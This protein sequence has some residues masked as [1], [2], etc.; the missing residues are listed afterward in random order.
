MSKKG[1]T[2]RT[3]RFLKLAKMTASVAGRYAGQKVQNVFASEAQADERRS[4]VYTRMADEVVDTLGELKGAVMKLGQIASQTQDFLPREFSAALQKLQKEA[5]PVEF[6]VIEGQIVR[7]LGATPDQLFKTFDRAPFAAASIGQVHRAVTKSGIEVVV[8]V[9]YP[10]VD[11]SCDSDLKQLKLTL[12]LGGLLKVP[13]ESVDE[14]FEEVKA[15]LHEELDYENEAR[16]I[17]RFRDFHASHDGILVPRVIDR[18]STRR[19]LTLEYLEG[20]HVN[21]LDRKGYD[22]PT[23]NLIGERLFRVLVEQ[24]FMF[25]WIHGDPHPGNFAFRKDGSVVI[26]DF[27]CVKQL[28]PDIV[29]AYA[30]AIEASLAEDY[31]AL[32]DAM[33]RL[34]ARVRG[35]PSPG[36][37]YY[38]VWRDIFLQPFLAGEPYDFRSSEMHL[39][40]AK[41][42]ALFFRY[43]DHFR[44]PVESMFIDRM[45]GG[46]YWLA[47]NLG[48]QG[49]FGPILADYVKRYRAGPGQQH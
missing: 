11:E 25:Q 9:Q 3:G 44:P 21:D 19:V 31:D 14:L 18:F 15:R 42:T 40:V 45:M 47:R 23:I 43:F 34:G 26:Y 27:G 8:K 6:E 48:V 24:L 41:N 5:P 29:R 35:K 1:T 4:R 16:N 32:D 7:E 17:R 12:K 39:Q 20:D 22:Q 13:K 37:E 10:G 36:A 28:K 46:Q 2:T 30:D 49:R 38:K 33:I